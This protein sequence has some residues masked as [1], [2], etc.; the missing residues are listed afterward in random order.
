MTDVEKVA[1]LLKIARIPGPNRYANQL[2][3]HL[4]QD[5][6]NMDDT[7]HTSFDQNHCP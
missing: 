7:D 4:I 6:I 1:E 2:K 3:G 5:I